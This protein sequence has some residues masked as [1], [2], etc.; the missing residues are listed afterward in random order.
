M[1]YSVCPAVDYR[2]VDSA[3]D[4]SAVEYSAVDHSAV[5]SRALAYR[6][7]EYS[8]AGHGYHYSDSKS[9]CHQ[10]D[11]NR[12]MLAQIL[13]WSCSCLRAELYGPLLISLC[14]SA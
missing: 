1:L 2:A 8:A 10:Y 9:C 4:F 11:D 13:L 3:V 7:V 5:V 6:A 12:N 14:A